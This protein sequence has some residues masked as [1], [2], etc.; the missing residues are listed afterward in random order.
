M[1]YH[2]LKTDPEPFAAVVEGSKT[3]EIRLNDRDFKTGDVLVLRETTHTGAEIAAGAA[4]EYTGR[5]ALAE[6]THVQTGYGLADNWAVLSITQT[7]VA[8][9]RAG[10]QRETKRLEWDEPHRD[11]VAVD[12][13]AAAMKGK[14]ATKRDQGM[15]GWD[16]PVACPV[17]RLQQMLLEHIGKGDPVD[18]GNLA[19]MLWNR[20]APVAILPP[21][22][23]MQADALHPGYAKPVPA[24]GAAP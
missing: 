23:G 1:K 4:L 3:H 12:L 13:F 14:L 2:E 15:G 5:T 19:M 11:D 7:G 22:T 16:D 21:M 10:E 17:V 8:G 20:G 24:E 6:I 9:R 18:V